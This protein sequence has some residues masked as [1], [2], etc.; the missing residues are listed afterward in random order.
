MMERIQRGDNEEPAK[1]TE[2]SVY[3][4]KNVLV[5]AVDVPQGWA[6]WGYHGL[7]GCG[8]GR[9]TKSPLDHRMAR[10]GS[11][12]SGAMGQHVLLQRCGMELRACLRAQKRLGRHLVVSTIESP[13]GTLSD[14]NDRA[15]NTRSML[16]NAASF[17]W[18]YR[19]LAQ[20]GPSVWAPQASEWRKHLGFP[21][22]KRAEI[23][24]F[25]G[26]LADSICDTA[27]IAHVRGSS[28]GIMTHAREA[29]CIAL[30]TWVRFGFDDGDDI[31]S[32]WM[33]ERGIYRDKTTRPPAP[34][35]WA[36]HK[37]EPRGG[38]DGQRDDDADEEQGRDDTDHRDAGARYGRIESAATDDSDSDDA[39][40]EDAGGAGG[41]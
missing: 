14:L 17:G 35:L 39:H 27:G 29:I 40:H 5:A 19:D 7:M 36:P 26:R 30:C 33:K 20:A 3:E 6:V 32:R 31:A 16:S 11:G 38:G 28:G 22:M 12:F 1:G 18:W 13:Y 15:S 41:D 24:D 4:T 10:V 25:A 2:L 37:P 23:K 34:Y 21:K 8:E 9:G